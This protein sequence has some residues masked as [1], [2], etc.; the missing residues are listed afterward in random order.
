M[1]HTVMSNQQLKSSKVFDPIIQRHKRTRRRSIVSNLQ[2][3]AEAFRNDVLS[4]LTEYPD[5]LDD[6]EC[7][8]LTKEL[9]LIVATGLQA[10]IL[11]KDCSQ[12]IPNTYEPIAAILKFSSS[13]LQFQCLAECLV[14][15]LC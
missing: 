1:V 5:I 6:K 12:L 9:T 8:Q 2:E 11:L 10:A 4:A 7:N 3:R 14:P 13:S 15:C